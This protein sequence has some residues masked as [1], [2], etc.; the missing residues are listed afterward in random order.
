MMTCTRNIRK[1]RTSAGSILV[2]VV[3]G[4]F[5]FLVF[6]LTFAALYPVIK[7][8]EVMSSQESK[9]VQMTSRLIEHIQMLPVQD[10]NATSLTALNLIEPG[11]TAQPW[12]F[13][14]IPLDQAA[15]YSPD[16]VLKNANGTITTELLSGGSVKVNVNLTYTAVSG[17]TKTVKAYTVVGS[18]R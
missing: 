15:R 13:S 7:R 11:Q 1:R 5:F 4:M 10:I 18:F 6:A 16:Q 8:A 14:K 3:L 2:D 12:K 17:K 9:A